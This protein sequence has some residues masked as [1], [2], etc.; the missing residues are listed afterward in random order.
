MYG[1]SPAFEW[2]NFFSTGFR[3]GSGRGS[4]GPRHFGPSFLFELFGGQPQRAERGEVRYLILDT[5]KEKARHGYEIIQA[6]EEK[7]KGAYRPSPGTIY[8]TLQLLEELGHV[9]SREEG[10]KKLYEITE[11]GRAELGRRQEEVEDAYDRLRGENEWLDASEIHTLMRR[12]HRLMRLVG[13]AFRHGRID[14]AEMRKILQILEEA[15]GRIEELVK[16]GG[17]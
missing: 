11:E 5:L 1:H 17:E 9:R 2:P 16:G 8:P 3:C 4:G 15:A 14:S 7:T 13:R 12:V 6:I 10:G